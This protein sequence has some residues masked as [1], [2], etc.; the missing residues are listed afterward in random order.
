[1]L[2]QQNLISQHKYMMTQQK[3]AVSVA[4]STTYFDPTLIDCLSCV[5][6][7]RHLVSVS[8]SGTHYGCCAYIIDLTQY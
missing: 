8:S 2:C 6:F 5:D 3:Y 7:D 4:C 1:M